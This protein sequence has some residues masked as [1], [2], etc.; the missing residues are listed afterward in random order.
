M[1]VRRDEFLPYFEP[2][3]RL[4]RDN[5]ALCYGIAIAAVVV[6]GLIRYLLEGLLIGV[7]FITFF[8]AVIIAAF[9]GGLGPGLLAILLSALTSVYFFM[10]PPFSFG[11]TVPLLL[12]FLMAGAQVALMALLN[13]AIDR[14]AR[15]EQ[16][17]RIIL[18][19]APAGMIA[20]DEHGVITLVNATVEKLFGYTP[21]EL[22][23]RSIELLV[24]ERVRAGHAVLRDAYLQ[25]P[26]TR[27]MGAG[28]DLFGRQK[29]G[30]EVPVEVGLNPVVREDKTGALATIVD[31]SERK[32]AERKQQVLVREV[33]HRAKNLLSIIQ[34]ISAR[35]FTP[36]RP[37]EQSLASF[38]AT[39]KALARTQDLFFASGRA[40]LAAL[41]E[42]EIVGFSDQVQI[43]GTDL[44]LNPISS[45]NLT[46]IVHELATNALKY[47]ALSVPDGK[48]S[49]RWRVEDAQL[50]FAWTET[51][52]PT[53]ASPTRSGFGQVILIDLAMSLGASVSSS[54]PPNGFRY[55]LKV[56]LTVVADATAVSD[57]AAAA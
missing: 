56:P 54:Y 40:T 43:E 30:A 2:L 44:A 38:D 26:T 10:Q 15:Q 28:R 31:I 46:L 4:R 53:V 11:V 13:G 17:T 22:I 45:Q 8:L 34:V 47:G 1:P 23:G 37:V 5:R 42:G 33:Q 52:G 57:S 18:D 55:E 48:V 6:A 25:Y 12:F 27:S 3:R 19:N 51:D 21:D 36:D 9:F 49:A 20:V 7:P 16:N 29:D 50:V 32:A 14:L 24:P 41:I 39:L 35:T